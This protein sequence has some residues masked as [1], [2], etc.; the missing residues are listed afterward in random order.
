VKHKMIVR[1]RAEVDLASHFLY[2][3][4]RSPQAAL[5]FDKA[6]AEA[7]KRIKSDPNVGARLVLP[8]VE[9]LD[10]R[11]Y[12]PKGFDKYLI[13]YRLTSDRIYV[14]RILHGSQDIEAAVVT[15]E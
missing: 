10:P 7:L 15:G 12:R 8:R 6:V 14:L 9:H 5:R 1:P 2:L 13:V 3:S 11:F 4:E